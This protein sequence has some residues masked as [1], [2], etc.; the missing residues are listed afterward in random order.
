MKLRAGL[1][2]VSLRRLPEAMWLDGSPVTG[3]GTYSRL[4]GGSVS[5]SPEGFKPYVPEVFDTMRARATGKCAADK[6]AERANKVRR[7]EKAIMK[8]LRLLD[9]EAEAAE[10]YDDFVSHE[11]AYASERLQ[12]NDG[13]GD[14]DAKMFWDNLTSP[15]SNDRFLHCAN[16]PHDETHRNAKRSRLSRL[17]M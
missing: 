4:C 11:R 2:P 13:E 16:L 8:R 9:A 14:D 10:L 1:H 3:N 7:R 12:T 15:S 6:H 17:G 5:E